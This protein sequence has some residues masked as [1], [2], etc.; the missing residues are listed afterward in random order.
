MIPLEMNVLI[1]DDISN[2]GLK[3]EQA[4]KAFDIEAS[5]WYFDKGSD[6]LS[7]IQTGA[8]VDVCF[9]D[10][11]MPEMNGIE[12]ARQIRKV[13]TD[14]GMQASEIVFLT[15]SN[16]F[17][18]ESFELKAFSYIL[19]PPEPQKVANILHEI[20]DAKKALDTSGI[21]ISTKT[22]TKFLYFR[23]VSFIEVIN[24]KVYFRL[25]DGSEIV[26]VSSLGAILPQVITDKRFAQC[27]RSFVVN[28]DDINKIQDN[29][30]LMYSGRQ[31]PISRTYAGFCDKYI[32]YLTG[33]SKIGGKDGNSQHNRNKME[34]FTI[35]NH[36]FDCQ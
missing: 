36:F 25:I 21:L 28:M 3:L 20:I 32:E 22:M 29:S 12:L 1:C 16:E 6:A 11:V 35:V 33:G 19:K 14:K 8:K 2:D 23:E 24:Y 26:I 13:E 10:I 17:A 27:H 31:I 18:S 7:H 30:V 9:L 5:C 34:H 4:I 15:T